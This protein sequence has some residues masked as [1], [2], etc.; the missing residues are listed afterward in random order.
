[1]A[2]HEHPE[3]PGP[4]AESLADEPIPEAGADGPAD[5]TAQ[6]RAREWLTQ[7][8]TMIQEIAA[9]AAP[10]ARQVGSKAAELAGVA[11]EQAAP[12]ARQ[13]GAKAAELA[14]VAASKA[15]PIAQRAAEVT[16]DAGQRFAD[17]A[18]SVAAELRS[19]PGETAPEEPAALPAAASGEGPDE[20]GPS[21]ET[22]PA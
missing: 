8:E 22:P 9:Q 11:A 18:Q 21:G 12:V 13:V 10:V 14:S 15:G 4:D 19:G 3:Q 1:M 6:A 20:A 2:E 17:R 5:P 16:T 7:L